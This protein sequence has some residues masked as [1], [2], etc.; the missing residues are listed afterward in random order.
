MINKDDNYHKDNG[1][2]FHES[3]FISYG[4]EWST[5]YFMLNYMNSYDNYTKQIGNLK[6]KIKI[7]ELKREQCI[8]TN[9]K[10]TAVVIK[11]QSIIRRFLTYKKQLK[12][13]GY[14]MLLAAKRFR[15]LL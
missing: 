7:T 9:P 11:I 15:E 2:H 3:R 6:E 1:G 14:L 13:G 5:N 12:P 4:H 8:F 10:R